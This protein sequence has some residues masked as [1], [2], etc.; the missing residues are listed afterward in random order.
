MPAGPG[1][2][3][4]LGAGDGTF[5]RALATRLGTGGR[6]HAVDRDTRGLKGLES[7][8]VQVVHANLEQPFELPG[9]A[10]GTLDGI[11]L[12]NT[13]H[14]IR[15]GRGVLARLVEWLRP[16]GRA[17]LIEYDQRRASRW[18]PYPIRPTDL[19]ALFDAAGLTLPE[20]VARA[21]SAFGG[22]M[23]VAVGRKG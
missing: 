2:W 22:E 18:V 23:Y 8:A 12:A 6:I 13:L 7:A 10:P 14:F 11:L 19:P 15:D 17:V 21:P 4:D 3:A 9:A 16:G 5:T 20:V 1:A